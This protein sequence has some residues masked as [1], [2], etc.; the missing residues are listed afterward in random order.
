MTR[1]VALVPPPVSP[2]SRRAIG[3]PSLAL[4]NIYDLIINGCKKL[5]CLYSVSKGHRIFQIDTIHDNQKH[6]EVLVTNKSGLIIASKYSPSVFGLR[7]V[8]KTGQEFLTG[9]Q[10]GLVRCSLILYSS[11][12]CCLKEYTYT[13]TPWSGGGTFGTSARAS[14]SCWW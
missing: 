13:C 12:L 2:R 1:D 6:Q 10:D 5:V 9:S 11:Y 14:G 8:G 4:M 3:T 7:W